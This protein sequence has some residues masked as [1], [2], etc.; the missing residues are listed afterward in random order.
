MSIINLIPASMASISH[1][2]ALP[3]IALA[4]SLLVGLACVACAGEVACLFAS[5]P[6]A[7]SAYWMLSAVVLG[8]ELPKSA[9]VQIEQGDP[10]YRQILST[11]MR[12]GQLTYGDLYAAR[13][14]YQNEMGE[15]ARRSMVDTRASTAST[16]STAA[17]LA[18]R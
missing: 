15:R 3:A 16:A 9:Y 13:A 11:R 17:T 8:T 4:V 6:L 5:M 2:Y 12:D 18:S 1:G 10:H 7:F 14:Q